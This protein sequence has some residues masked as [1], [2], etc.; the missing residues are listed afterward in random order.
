VFRNLFSGLSGITPVGLIAVLT[1]AI[2]MCLIGLIIYC[3]YATRARPGDRLELK[4]CKFFHLTV[5]SQ[6][7]KDD[8]R[9]DELNENGT[10]GP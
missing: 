10:P 4:I 3:V 2:L 7:A 8:E 5:N 1:A 9:R 6:D